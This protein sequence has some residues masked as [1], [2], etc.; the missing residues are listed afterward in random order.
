MSTSVKERFEDEKCLSQSWVGGKKRRAEC[1]LHNGGG[2]GTRC[3]WD[4]CAEDG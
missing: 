2:Q 1:H 3:K 4:A